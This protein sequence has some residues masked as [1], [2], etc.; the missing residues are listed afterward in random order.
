MEMPCAIFA[1]PAGE[2]VIARSGEAGIMVSAGV[3]QGKI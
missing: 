3:A 2:A 1:R